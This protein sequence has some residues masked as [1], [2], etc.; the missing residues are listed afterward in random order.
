MPAT[1]YSPGPALQDMSLMCG[2]GGYT[3]A[4]TLTA[5]AGGG[6]ANALPLTKA[7]NRITTVATTA[8]SVALPQAFGGQCISVVNSGAN[9]MQI[10]AAMGS[11]DTINGTAGSTGISLAAN[12][13]IEFKSFVGRWFGVLSA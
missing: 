6:Q 8:D 11:S 7:L 12:K 1:Q 13:A 4:D 10:F 5:A 3:F 2:G 9:A